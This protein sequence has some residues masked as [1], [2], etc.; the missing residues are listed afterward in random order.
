[1]DFSLFISGIV[2]LVA[3][4]VTLFRP[5][6]ARKLL[7]L[8]DSE[9]ATYAL[10]MAGTMVGAFGLVLVGFGAVLWRT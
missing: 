1:M 4:S 7:H 5:S 6:A 3:G 2:A 8:A 10:R 9:G